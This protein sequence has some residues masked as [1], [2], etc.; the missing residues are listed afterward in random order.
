[1]I[2]ILH[3]LFRGLFVHQPAF[4]PRVLRIGILE[5][6][7][8][9]FHVAAAAGGKHVESLAAEVVGLDEGVDDGWGGVPPHGEA[10]PNHIIVG[11]VLAAAL[12]GG[13]RGLVLHLDGRA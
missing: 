6:V 2:L 5:V 9:A 4:A 13:T 8:R 3:F 1:M 7:G 12:D 11:N 10:D